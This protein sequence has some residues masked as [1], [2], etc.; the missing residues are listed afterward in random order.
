MAQNQS[1]FT[2]PIHFVT[3][4]NNLEFLNNLDFFIKTKI[5]TCVYFHISYD[6]VKYVHTIWTCVYFHIYDDL[7]KYVHYIWTCVYF[8]IYLS[9]MNCYFQILWT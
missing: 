2:N 1:T 8:H 9:N 3:V 4:T 5:W 7:V 6:L